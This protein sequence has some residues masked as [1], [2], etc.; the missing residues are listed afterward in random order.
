M[1]QCKKFPYRISFRLL[2][3]VIFIALIIFLLWISS[4]KQ[5][6]RFLIEKIVETSDGIV[7]DIQGTI[8]NGIKIN[9]LT[10]RSSDIEID[11][12]ELHIDI[13]L[14]DIIRGLLH[15]KKISANSLVIEKIKGFQDFSTQ[16]EKNIKCLRL[17]I[18][19]RLD[20]L[21]IKDIICSFQEKY[22]F[23]EYLREVNIN[24]FE[25]NIVLKKISGLNLKGQAFIECKK[26][27]SWPFFVEMDITNRSIKEDCF[28]KKRN[29][30]ENI[31]FS[32]TD[33]L[34]SNCKIKFNG[35]IEKLSDNNLSLQNQIF[36]DQEIKIFQTKRT[37]INFANLDIYLGQLDCFISASL[38]LQQSDEKIN[39]YNYLEIKVLTNNINLENLIHNKFPTTSLTTEIIFNF[40]FYDKKNLEKSILI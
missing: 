25:D 34:L 24:Y 38:N 15:I 39:L 17:P 22:K 18:N 33:N 36:S 16:K 4:S 9:Q 29:I 11:I 14:S 40:L 12:S 7:G 19:I 37:S 2:I 20:E 13:V 1:N 27:N 21:D 35:T 8:L 30:I 31:E 6:S 26:M 5:G 10:L 3:T 32:K 23:L 28:N